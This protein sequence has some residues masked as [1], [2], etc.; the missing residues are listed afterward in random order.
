MPTVFLSHAAADKPLVD[1]LKTMLQTAIGLGPDEFFYSSG[2]GTGVP[3]GQ[4]FVEYIRSSLDGATF[5]LAVITPSFRG[6]EFCLA[7]LGAVWLAADKNFYPLCVPKVD[8]ASLKATLTGIQ[9][10]RI[11]EREALAELL[12]RIAHHF[13]RDY[14]AAA[15]DSAIS[16]FLGTLGARLENLSKPAMVASSELDAEKETTAALGAELTR[17][18][19]QVAAERRRADEILEAKTREEAIALSLPQDERA[20]IQAL[21]KSARDAVREVK[22]AVAMALPFYLRGDEMPWPDRGDWAYEHV[23][24]AVQDGHLKETGEGLTVV[25][26]QD[27]PDVEAAAAAC[28]ELQ[29]CLSRLDV[30][31]EEWFKQTYGVPADIRQGAVFREVVSR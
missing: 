7:E 29:Q 19:D 28:D 5:V 27:W 24:G 26:N 12:Q 23:V 20:R 31:G 14:N 6:S 16:M 8:R 22:P 13:G 2:A 15:C 4:N 18:R 1:D 17:T 11:D 9:V 30:A 10:A 25:I 21:I 3:T